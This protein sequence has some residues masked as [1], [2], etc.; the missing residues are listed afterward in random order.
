MNRLRDHHKRFIYAALAATASFYFFLLFKVQSSRA[1]LD[2]LAW[3]GVSWS[4]VGG[5]VVILYEKWVWRICNRKYDFAGIWRFTET[6]YR[7]NPESL[8][9]V[10]AC[11]ARGSMRIVQDLRSICIVEG[12]TY[13]L[14]RQDT[15]ATDISNTDPPPANKTSDWWSIACEL[16][17]N[18]SKIYG[19]LDHESTLERKG[20]PIGYGIEVFRVRERT[21]SGRPIRMSSTVYHCIGAGE[22]RQIDVNYTRDGFENASRA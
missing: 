7:V 6:Q 18:A 12:Q 17:E 22:P 20:K 4:V 3:F 10:V 2:T 8:E 19:A 11:Y 15:A 16:D 13:E 21:K 1:T 9:A 14:N 5:L